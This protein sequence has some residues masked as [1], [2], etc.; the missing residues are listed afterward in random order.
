MNE[1]TFSL[2]GSGI[3]L[4]TTIEETEDHIIWLLQRDEEYESF[5]WWDIP[6]LNLTRIDSD[7]EITI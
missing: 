4:W 1:P 2:D 6:C 3:G 7:G 5:F